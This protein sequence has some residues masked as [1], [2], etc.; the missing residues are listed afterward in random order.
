[1]LPFLFSVLV[2]S[3][4]RANARA[5]AAGNA[6]VGIDNVLIVAG[7]NS[8]DGA[9]ICASAAHDAFV[10]DLVSHKDYLLILSVIFYH[11]N[12]DLYILFIKNLN[13]IRDF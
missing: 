5:S 12:G 6:G 10:V 8:G 7:G 2:G 13:P 9:V 11:I 3:T 4:D 1:M